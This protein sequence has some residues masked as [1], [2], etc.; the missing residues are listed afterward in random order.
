[1]TTISRKTLVEKLL[2]LRGATFV[3]I[4][5]TTDA[6]AKKTNNPYG[7]IYKTTTNNCQVNF[8]YDNAVLNRLAKEGKDASEFE[9]GESW[10]TPYKPHG[11]LTP[12]ATKKGEQEPNY[13]RVRHLTTTGNTVYTT[14]DGTEVEYPNIQR[15]LPKPSEYKNQGTDEPVRFLTYSLESVKIIKMDG[16]TYLVA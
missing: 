10:H 2:G 12:L 11:F 4:T 1:V 3:T 5:T 9:R 7:T 15:F 14:Q 6:R 16:E 8:H 13:L